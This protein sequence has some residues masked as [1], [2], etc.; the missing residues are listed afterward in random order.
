MLKFRGLIRQMEI[1]QDQQERQAML[2]AGEVF[3]HWRMY[4]EATLYEA[5]RCKA[6]MDGRQMQSEFD[7]DWCN[8]AALILSH[9]GD[10]IG[11][12]FLRSAPATKNKLVNAILEDGGLYDE[13]EHWVE[14]PPL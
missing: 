3:T 1:E 5:I 13:R 2:F 9:G 11:D 4:F 12:R 14:L 7:A 8:A 10:P 6:R